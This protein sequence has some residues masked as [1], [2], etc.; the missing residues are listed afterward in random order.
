LGVPE[1]IIIKYGAVSSEVVSAMAENARKLFFVDYCVATSGVAGP[2]G[3]S[4]AKPVGLV[5][6]AVASQAGVVAEKFIYGTDRETNLQR[7]SLAALNIL[8]KQILSS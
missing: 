6:I 5:W 8:R 4:D 2:G 1:N 7:F 3:G